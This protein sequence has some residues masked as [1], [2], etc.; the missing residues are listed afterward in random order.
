MESK[1]SPNGVQVESKWSPSGVP[2]ESEWSPNGYAKGINFM[3]CN[4]LVDL[5]K[6]SLSAHKINLCRARLE[7]L[8]LGSQITG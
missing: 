8:T 4:S 7:P 1:W 5:V 6:F 3:Q 2:M